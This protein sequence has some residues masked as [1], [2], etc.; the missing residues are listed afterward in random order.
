MEFSKGDII[1]VI[2]RNSDGRWKGELNN[3]V[4]YFPMS[5]V[6]LI[7]NFVKNDEPPHV[8]QMKEKDRLIFELFAALDISHRRENWYVKQQMRRNMERKHLELNKSKP[9]PQTLRVKDL[10]VENYSTVSA[11]PNTLR[12]LGHVKFQRKNKTTPKPSSEFLLLSLNEPTILDLEV[13]EMCYK[14]TP[15]YQKSKQEKILVDPVT[16][17]EVMVKLQFARDCLNLIRINGRP[18]EGNS[19][20]EKVRNAR[21]MILEYTEHDYKK[22]K[23]VMEL[24]TQNLGIWLYDSYMQKYLINSDKPLLMSQTGCHYIDV[25]MEKIV[26]EEKQLGKKNK[27]RYLCHN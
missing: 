3:L 9:S 2:E 4:G 18:I 6:E 25:L 22:T 8:K 23:L 17:E 21:N 13:F 10:Q 7:D 19:D 12:N 15:L 24:A 11:S 16:K 27:K 5:F 26:T 14:E 20:E 1:N